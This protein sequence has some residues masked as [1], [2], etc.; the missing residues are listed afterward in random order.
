M[1][2]NAIRYAGKFTPEQLSIAKTIAASQARHQFPAGGASRMG[3][4]VN[5]QAYKIAQQMFGQKETKE[6]AAPEPAPAETTPDPAQELKIA[7]LTEQSQ[8]YRAQSEEQLAAANAKIAELSDTQLQ[9]QKAKELQQRFAITAAANQA[10][11]AQTANLQIAP[12]S[13]TP[14]TGGTQ[15]FKRRPRQ[16]MRPIGQTTSKLT[17][18]TSNVLNI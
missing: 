2:L 13:A 12:A 15:S 9:A 18:P 10:R 5:A 14:M 4:W 6:E 11:G 8:A 1:L 7:E 3:V 17:V 16:F